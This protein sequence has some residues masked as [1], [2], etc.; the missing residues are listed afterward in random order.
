[1]LKLLSD[2]ND[3]DLLAILAQTLELDLAGLQS[4]Q[5][6][7]AALTHVN[8]GM[9]MG[10]AL[11]NQNVASQNELTVA[12]LHAQTLGLG[13]TAVTGRTN[14]LLVGE[15]LQTDIQRSLHLHDGNKFRILLCQLDEVDHQTG[16]ECLTGA[17]VGLTQL[18]GEF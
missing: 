5:G 16:Q 18:C 14:A 11:T 2:L 6:V 8:T 10:A 1:M 12:A 7:V 3:R 17:L 4:E 15:K 9:D 13:V